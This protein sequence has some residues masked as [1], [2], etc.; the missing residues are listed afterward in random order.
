MEMELETTVANQNKRS[1][2]EVICIDDD[3]DEI[4][5]EV[6]TSLPPDLHE[7]F[8]KSDRNANFIILKDETYKFLMLARPKVK[9]MYWSYIS[10]DKVSNKQ[11]CIL[12]GH[13]T[14]DSSKSRQT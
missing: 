1:I 5:E 12:C 10:R 6:L 9:N 3:A 4:E 13:C 14:N 2:N 11:I 7:A 8:H